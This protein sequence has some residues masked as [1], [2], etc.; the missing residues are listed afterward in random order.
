MKSKFY[1]SIT[2]FVKHNYIG[3][4]ALGTVKIT[5]IDND[6]VDMNATFSKTSYSWDFDKQ[7]VEITKIK[8]AKCLDFSGT[9]TDKDGNVGQF[10]WH[11]ECD[12]LDGKG[13]IFGKRAF[14][15]M[16]GKGLPRIIKNLK[17]TDLSK[18]LHD[19][20]TTEEIYFD[21]NWFKN[22]NGT[23]NAYGLVT[24]DGGVSL[25]KL[26]G[27]DCKHLYTNSNLFNQ[28]GA[29]YLVEL[30]LFNVKENLNL[31]K[32]TL[33]PREQLVRLFNEGLVTFASGTHTLTL[34][35]TLLAKLTDEDKKIATDKGWTLA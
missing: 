10:T 4:N 14:G 29:P 32:S 3:D 13:F 30:Q 5:D 24:G 27:L 2:T 11:T 17:A 34:G 23:I 9:I 21:T 20:R 28:G 26:I 25:T 6:Y 12:I 35:S 1:N 8:K 16:D 33:L 18:C 15:R 19:N 22:Y 7:Q 31:S